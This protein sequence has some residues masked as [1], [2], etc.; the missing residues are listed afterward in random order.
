MDM[1]RVTIAVARARIALADLLAVTRC[2]ENAD[3]KR[4]GADRDGGDN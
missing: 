2:S 3:R 1:V 4:K